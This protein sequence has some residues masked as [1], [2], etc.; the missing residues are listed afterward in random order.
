IP[1]S[2]ISRKSPST[3]HRGFNPADICTS[4]TANTGHLV[5]GTLHTNTAV[6]TVSRIVDMFPAEQQNQI[7]SV[8]AD[9]LKAV[10][11][12]TLCRRIG[13]GRV[14]VLEILVTDTG[15]CNLIRDNKL[16]QILSAMQMGRARGNRVLNEELSRLVE[17]KIVSQE[18][19]MTKAADKADLAD[20]FKNIGEATA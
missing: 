15:I 19:A 10:V 3:R 8:L 18:E 9:I 5:F 2:W 1:A 16:H 20:K 12:Q 6:S 4:E 13:G 11:A 7:R 17:E 14:A